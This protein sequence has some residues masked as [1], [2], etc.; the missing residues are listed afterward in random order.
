MIFFEISNSNLNMKYNDKLNCC[1][2]EQ[3][4]SMTSKANEVVKTLL[5]EEDLD[6][7]L[8]SESQQDLI[9]KV[10]ALV[11]YIRDQELPH[12]KRAKSSSAP[13]SES[14]QPPSAPD[15]FYALMKNPKP[16]KRKSITVDEFNDIIESHGISKSIRYDTLSLY[17]SVSVNWDPETFQFSFSGTY[18]K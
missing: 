1:P 16:F 8:A 6:E 3:L 7:F 17:G 9:D 15:V 13:S 14:S 2:N 18:G 11:D 4:K 12:K 5:Q 10:K